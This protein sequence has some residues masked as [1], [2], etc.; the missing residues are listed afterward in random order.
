MGLEL[1]QVDDLVGFES[2]FADADQRAVNAEAFGS[3]ERAKG[4]T[5]LSQRLNQFQSPQA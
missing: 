4:H 1:W 5:E 2:D 3:V